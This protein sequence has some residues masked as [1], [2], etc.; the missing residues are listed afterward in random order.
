MAHII[1]PS[2][3]DELVEIRARYDALQREYIVMR[4]REQRAMTNERIQGERGRSAARRTAQEQMLGLAQ[5]HADAMVRESMAEIHQVLYVADDITKRALT[6]TTAQRDRLRVHVEMA[7]NRIRHAQEREGAHEFLDRV[8]AE[9]ARLR[10]YVMTTGRAIHDG[11]GRD[12]L[13]CDCTGC[14]LIIG[15]DLVDGEGA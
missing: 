10:A 4:D 1:P 15:M 9:V 3:H 8:H 5:V 13:N 7:R 6:A 11:T 14:M 12:A 2:E